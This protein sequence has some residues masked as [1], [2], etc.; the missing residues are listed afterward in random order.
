MAGESLC[1][2]GVAMVVVIRERMVAARSGVSCI[3]PVW[4]VVCA[5]VV[6]KYMLEYRK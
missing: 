3:L 5:C 4:G 2:M 1:V 6:G